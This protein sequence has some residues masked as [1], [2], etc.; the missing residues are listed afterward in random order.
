MK[1]IAMIPARMGSQRLPKKN[2][3]LLDGVPLIVRA[4]R[5]CKD[6]GVFD[7][8][9][10]NSE[11]PDFG[12]VAEA[13]GA[14]FHQ[15]PHALGDNSATSEDFV[16]EFLRAHT[17]DFVVQV[18]SIAP[19]L[20]VEDTCRFVEMVRNNEFDAVMSV[21]HGQLECVFDDEPVNFTFDKKENSQDLRPVKRIVWSITAWRSETFLAAK[22]SGGCATYAGRIGYSEVSQMAGHVIKTQEDLDIAAAMLPIV[23][24]A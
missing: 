6:A 16:T 5:K 23:Q 17:C 14:Q 19:L 2:L 4:I 11:H 10:V 1:I 22:E 8:I 12:P 24:G 13:E 9:W 3:A 21:V 18:H 7:E 15:R 20:S